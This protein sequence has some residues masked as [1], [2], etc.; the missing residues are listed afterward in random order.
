MTAEEA[1]LIIE[2]YSTVNEI[3]QDE[4]QIDFDKALSIIKQALTPP[5]EQEVCEALSEWLKE[6]KPELW[7]KKVQHDTG[8]FH[9]YNNEDYEV[10]LV[11]YDDIDK[12]MFFTQWLPP[13]LITMIGSFYEGEV[14]END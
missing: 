1:L 13:H 10:Y 9:Y 3:G 14:K 11:E 5:T 4:M 8:G 2:Y 12:T 6:D 7:V